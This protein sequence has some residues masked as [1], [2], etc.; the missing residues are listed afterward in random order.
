MAHMIKARCRYCGTQVR[1]FGDICP[2][3]TDTAQDADLAD[4]LRRCTGAREVTVTRIGQGQ[5]QARAETVR[6]Q[7]LREA[8]LEEIRALG[9]QVGRQTDPFAAYRTPGS[10][11]TR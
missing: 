3:C 4:S 11:V 1:T 9:R 8:R 6:Q 2:G 10:S 5:A 7:D